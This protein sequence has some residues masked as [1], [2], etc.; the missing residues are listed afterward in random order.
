M[1]GLLRSIKRATFLLLMLTSMTLAFSLSPSVSASVSILTLNPASGNVGT[2]VQVAA[3]ITT[4]N[5]GFEILFNDSLVTSGNATGNNVDAS[6]AVPE[7]AG[8]NYSVTVID[9]TSGE[10]DSDVFSVLPFYFLHAVVPEAPRQLQENDSVPIYANITGGEASIVNVANV[11]VQTPAGS[12]FEKMIAFGTSAVGTGNAVLNY[13][14]DFPSG[15]NT[16]FVGDYFVFF[17]GTLDMDL[18]SVGLTNST[19][20]HRYDSV[21]IRAAY[22]PEENVTIAIEGEDLYTSVNVTASSDGIVSY[23]SWTVP[24]NASVGIYS[25]SVVSISVG[26]TVKTPSDSQDFTIPGF[27]VNVT[28]RNLAGDPVLA[29]EI[30][31][32]EGGASVANATTGSTGLATLNLEIGNYSCEAHYR[33]VDVG[34]LEVEVTNLTSVELVCNLTNLRVLTVAVVKGAEVRVPEAGIFLE[35]LNDTVFTDITGAGV[36]HSLLPNVSY[37]VNVSRY[38]VPFNLTV[39]PELLVNGSLTPWYDVTV[40]CP[41]VHLE[42]TVFKADRTPF[43]G[44]VVRIQERLGGVEYEANTNVDGT[45]GFDAIFGRYDLRVYDSRGTKLNETSVELFQDENSTV[46]CSTYGLVF[47]VRVV[48]YFGQPISGANVTVRG[49]EGER[50]SS[51]TDGDGKATFNNVIGGSLEIAVYLADQTQPTVVTAIALDS[52]TTTQLEVG[53]YTVLAGFLVETSQLTIAIIIVLTVV[54]ILTLEIY[55]ARRAKSVKKE[56]KSE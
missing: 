8:G 30:R 26:G 12:V 35:P 46:Y 25:V 33:S 56:R 48:D 7:T 28:A 29:A 24:A 3:T 19:E 16:Q 6:F 13:P 39:I 49:Q 17:N 9:V 45:V 52:S 53:K 15:A 37:T 36:F 54:A 10:N 38:D 21:G 40:F 27:A 20:Y 14:N 31:A 1:K 2:S 51:K 50:V 47:S 11:T 32:S 55:R 5:G 41:T 4:E 34:Q 18:F 44:A 23:S 42:V 43:E 22:K